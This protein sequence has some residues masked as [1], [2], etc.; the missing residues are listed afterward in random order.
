VELVVDWNKNWC[1]QP[2]ASYVAFPFAIP[3]GQLKLEAAGGFF[4]P[5]S[6]QSR[7]QLPGTCANYY[8]LQR[9]AHINSLDGAE[10]LW[11]PLDAPLVMPNAINYANWESIPWDWNGFLASMPINHYW[12]TNFSPSQRGRLRLR[13]RMMSKAGW[14]DVES[15]IQAASP[16][17]ALGWR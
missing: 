4:Q 14:S 10:L 1:S 2:E 16:I 6:H 15:A 12:V 11:L 3:N 9:A 8:T 13:Y 5:G 7:G 17:E